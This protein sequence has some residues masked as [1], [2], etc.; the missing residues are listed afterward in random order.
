M[1]ETSMQNARKIFIPIAIF[2][3]IISLWFFASSPTAGAARTVDAVALFA[4]G[5]ASGVALV[6]LF[7]RRGAAS[8]RT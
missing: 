1:K 8:L 5:L 2:M 7:S 6:L 4:A 3:A